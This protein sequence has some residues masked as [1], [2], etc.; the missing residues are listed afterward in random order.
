MQTHHSFLALVI[1]AL[2]WACDGG[3]ENGS[4]EPTNPPAD[5]E[6]EVGPDSDS[7]S[8]E[9]NVEDEMDVATRE[10]DSEAADDLPPDDRADA[11]NDETGDDPTGVWRSE[12]YPEDWVMGFG[13]DEGRFLHDFSYAGYHNGEVSVGASVPATTIDV[14]AEYGAD[15]TGGEDATEAIQ[16]AIDAASDIGG[17]VVF[18]EEG[19][20]RIDG[21][22]HVIASNTVIRGAGPEATRL[23]FTNIEGMSYASH[24]TVGSALIPGEEVAL[25]SDADGLSLVVQVADASSLEVG[26][27][28]AVGWVISEAFVEQHHMTDVWQAFNGSWQAFFWREI[29]AIDN[30]GEP[31]RVTV[32]VPLRY[33]ALT[34]DGASVRLYDG[35][36]RE[37]GV[38]QLAVSNA[39]GWDA[40]WESNQIHAIEVRGAAD[41]WIRDV[42]SFV[43]PSAPED[44]PGSGAHLASGGIIVRGSKRVTVADSVMENP[45]HRGGG[46]NGYLFEVR[47][48]SEVLFRD[49]IARRGRHNFIQNWGF[50]ATG[51]VWLRVDSSGGRA[52]SSRDGGFSQ[53]GLSE[54]H[55]SLAMANLI[56]SSRF[57]D[58]WAA[59]N[60]RSESTGAGHTATESVIWNV[61]GV[62]LV[63]S[64]QFGWGYVIGTGELIVVDDLLGPL[65]GQNAEPDDF[66]EGIGD[67]ETLEPASLYD[68]QLRRRLER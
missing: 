52:F 6:A 56:D 28:V 65:Y 33:P 32:D 26:D 60:R 57:D 17:A 20:Y 25:V 37:A 21:R 67:G 61:S 31:H 58:G 30:T 29:V 44:G 2:V 53:T 51:I 12:L 38:E 66:F 22:L 5:T 48:S 54:F 23:H 68:D 15:P 45:Q 8:D 62:G 4:T 35:Y 16:S 1:V 50:G 55:H 24:L 43:S 36:I 13:D 42:R 46:G 19:L 11:Q 3:T 49:D 41:C 47:T 59:A 9:M 18:L 39:V 14:V 63:R 27:D 34:R 7:A 64:F 10:V 40:A